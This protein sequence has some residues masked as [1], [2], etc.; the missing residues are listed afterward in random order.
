LPAAAVRPEAQRSRRPV[1]ERLGW[2]ITLHEREA[3]NRQSSR[4]TA[5]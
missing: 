5:G 1:G 2:V 3:I 4:A